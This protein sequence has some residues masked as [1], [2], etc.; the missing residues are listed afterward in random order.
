M[1]P[2]NP[3]LFFTPSFLP[4]SPASS[5]V[6]CI[7]ADVPAG[8]SFPRRW[9]NLAAVTDGGRISYDSDVVS[10]TEKKRKRINV[11][12]NKKE[13][14]VNA[15]ERWS[16]DRESYLT[17]DDDA[18]PLPMAYPN[19]TPVS[20]HEIDLRLRCDPVIEVRDASMFRFCVI[21]LM[22]CCK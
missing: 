21:S 19:T 2:L 9:F 4:F 1:L 11:R 12:N 22:Y 20:P 5:T 15:K 13:T 3:N 14:K 18:L 8:H 10:D 6:R 16:R 17:D 7:A